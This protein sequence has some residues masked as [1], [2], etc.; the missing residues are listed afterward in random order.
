MKKIFLFAAAVLC[1]AAMFAEEISS[2]SLTVVLPKAGTEI[3]SGKV[4]IPGDD[5]VA[6]VTIT[7]PDG[8]NY[9]CEMYDFFNEDG[10]DYFGGT[11]V[12]NTDYQLRLTITTKAG[13]EF[14]NPGLIIKVNGEDPYYVVNEV[15]DRYDFIVK[16]KASTATALDNTAV[17]TKSIKRIVNGQL[18]IE[19]DGKMYNAQ[20][21]QVK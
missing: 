6:G 12:E 1:S 3:T 17:E 5:D 11:L 16:F 15:S 18:F 14:V 8:A 2:V 7:C 10:S 4:Y 21:A 20:G 13:Y 9:V 19:R